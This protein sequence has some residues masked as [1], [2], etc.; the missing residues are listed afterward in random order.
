MFCRF[1]TPLS[2]SFNN[3]TERVNAEL[4]SGNYFQALGVRPAIG[5]VFSSEEDDRVYK[6]HPVVMLSHQYWVSRFA[7]DPGV[8]GKKILVNNYPMV[9]V[10]VSAAGF[11]GL[12]PSTSP[13]IRVPIQMK[14]LMTPGWDAM[15]DRR[16]QW[17]QTFARMKPGFT[18]SSSQASLQPLL[19]QILRSELT[20]PE[21]KDSCG[22][23]SWQERSAWSKRRMG[24]RTSV[25]ATRWR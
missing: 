9:I 24:I 7:A 2:V 3:Q 11:T 5:R 17:I 25:K 22:K 15:G 21:M 19:D 12:D 1:Y 16:S 4:V 10:G 23:N 18:L 8:I 13:Q 6:G 14:P 20:L